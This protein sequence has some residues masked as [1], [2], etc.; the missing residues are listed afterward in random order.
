M[1]QPPL[2]SVIDDDESLR[3]ATASLLR[4]MGYATECFAHAEAFFGAGDTARFAC[5]ISDIQMPGMDG[6]ELTRRL[7]AAD[8]GRKVILM[9][10]RGEQALLRQAR[11]SGAVGLLLK[12]FEVELLLGCVGDAVNQG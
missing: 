7:L 8:G 4:S 5:V 1:T 9:T 2:I 12:P 3:L 6:I 11:A 10:G